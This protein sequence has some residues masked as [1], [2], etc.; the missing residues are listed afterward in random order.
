MKQ[1]KLIA[2]VAAAQQVYA[3]RQRLGS[4]VIG[5]AHALKCDALACLGDLLKAMPKAK[6]TRGQLRGDVP[7]GARVGG[8]HV[9]QP[10]ATLAELGIDRKTSALARHL[11]DLPEKTRTAA[12]PIAARAQRGANRS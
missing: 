3:R 8:T 2:D 9:E 5:F 4:E 1:A 7:K 10:T 6:G 12:R 11:A